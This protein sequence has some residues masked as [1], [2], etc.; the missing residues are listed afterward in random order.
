MDGLLI[1]SEP[2]WQHAAEKV[3]ADL[4]HDVREVGTHPGLRTLE[5]A[6]IWQ[7][8]FGYTEPSIEVV[9][10]RVVENVISQA[11]KDGNAMPGAQ[12]LILELEKHHVPMAVASSSAMALIDVVLDKLNLRQ[13]MK[14]IH[15]GEHEERGKPYPDVFLSTAQTLGIQPEHCLV[16]EDSLNGVKAAKAASMYCIAVPQVPFDR[17]AFEEAKPDAII[18]SLQDIS[19]QQIVR[20]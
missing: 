10:Q 17:T 20:L 11:E 19:W 13:F 12:G 6:Q 9:A 3:L 8:Y 16:F 2:F 1:D 15:S 7:E 5:E 14:A 18:N 4:G